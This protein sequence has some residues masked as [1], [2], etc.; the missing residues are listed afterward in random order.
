MQE[1]YRRYLKGDDTG[2]AEIVMSYRE[3]LILYAY[4]FTGS[5]TAAEDLVDDIFFR[6]MVK[7]PH[8]SG[9]TSFKTWLYTM[10]R[11]RTIDYLRR[12]KRNP[13]VSVD[14]IQEL[15]DKKQLEESYI[16]KE[17]Q[18]AVYRALRQINASYQLVLHLSFFEDFDNAQI[19]SFLGKNKRQVEM[20]KYRGLQALKKEL[21]QEGLPDEIL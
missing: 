3:G 13:A 9:R 2:I 7:K 6:L 18:I 19:A 14:E 12:Q 1:S 8:F 15:A 11:H 17:R 4:H 5:M 16:K 21:E 10:T 20:L